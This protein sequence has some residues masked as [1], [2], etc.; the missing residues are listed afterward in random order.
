MRVVMVEE[1]RRRSLYIAKYGYNGVE[2]DSE[3]VNASVQKGC[4]GGCVKERGTRGAS[5][6]RDTRILEVHFGSPT[7]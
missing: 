3:L 4:V 1:M 7:V 6:L 5:E 2:I